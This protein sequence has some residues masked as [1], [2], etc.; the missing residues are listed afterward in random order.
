MKN[1]GIK[2]YAIGLVTGTLLALGGTEIVTNYHKEQRFCPESDSGV[3]G[4]DVKEV[5]FDYNNSKRTGNLV[6]RLEN[7]KKNE[8]NAI[9]RNVSINEEN[10]RNL[11]SRIKATKKNGERLLG[12]EG[13]WDKYG[14]LRTGNFNVYG[15]DFID[16]VRFVY[17]H[18]KVNFCF[19]KQ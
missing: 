11:A 16:T 1:E 8:F 19:E 17:R 6:L 7:S 15:I 4:V 12:L 18:E 14:N 5:G 3:F 13:K 2:F 10:L 9:A